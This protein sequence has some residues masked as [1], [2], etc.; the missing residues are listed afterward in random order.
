VTEPL[1]DGPNL[2]LTESSESLAVKYGGTAGLTS[3]VV[4]SLEGGRWQSQRVKRRTGM[5]ALIRPLNGAPSRMARHQDSLSRYH[6]KVSRRPKSRLVDG[7]KA[8][9]DSILLQSVA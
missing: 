8:S 3:R 1:R 5:N 6:L 4:A 2:Q 9:S 7:L